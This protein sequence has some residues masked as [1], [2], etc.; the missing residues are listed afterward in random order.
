M[1]AGLEPNAVIREKTHSNMT[2]VAPE[3]E[4]AVM[5]NGQAH[6]NGQLTTTG[7]KSRSGSDDER[8]AIGR[9]AVGGRS[10]HAK[11]ASDQ[12]AQG[13]AAEQAGVEASTLIKEKNNSGITAARPASVTEVTHGQP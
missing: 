10:E 11:V 6:N 4:A 13:L 12:A 7:N 2:V 9:G 3:G 8:S 1:P 5:G